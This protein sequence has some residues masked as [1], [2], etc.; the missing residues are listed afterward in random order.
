ME[1]KLTKKDF[2]TIPNF[3]SAFRLLL[4][5]VF[6]VLYCGR[7]LYA[8]AAMVVMLSA[9]TDF[10]DGRVARKFNMVSEVGKILDPLADKLTQG[11]MMICLMTR[12]RWMPLLLTLLV[13]KELLQVFC[14]DRALKATGIV[15]SAN[16]YGKV[17]TGVIY[18]VMICLFLFPALPELFATLLIGICAAALSASMI[19]YCRFFA[20]TLRR[21]Y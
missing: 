10:A 2:L 15:S 1:H 12:F 3:M 5:P 7:D 4:I 17:S 11:A 16:W 18:A 13:C 6:M 14:G 20:S 8:G 19:L 21:I 9:V